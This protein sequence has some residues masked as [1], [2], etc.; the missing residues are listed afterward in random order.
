MRARGTPES[1]ESS[2]LCCVEG[3][4]KRWTSDFGR[5]FCGAHD[6]GLSG[7]QPTKRQPQLNLATQPLHDVLPPFNERAER[8]GETS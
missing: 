2:L 1:Q 4:T 6:P 7:G 3:C 8:D 5:R